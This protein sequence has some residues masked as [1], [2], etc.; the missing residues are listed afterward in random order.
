MITLNLDYL[1][2]ACRI[3]SEGETYNTEFLFPL[4]DWQREHIVTESFSFHNPR[5]SNDYKVIW[6]VR[7]PM[8]G[9]EKIGI[10]LVR[11]TAHNQHQRCKFRFADWMF[12]YKDIDYQQ[13]ADL[14]CE[15][16][17]TFYI[18]NTRIDFAL[19]TD[20]RIFLQ[21]YSYNK[22]RRMVMMGGRDEYDEDTGMDGS[23]FATAINDRCLY[24]SGTFN[25]C[26]EANLSKNRMKFEKDFAEMNQFQA[27]RRRGEVETAYIGGRYSVQ[28]ARL[29][30][31]TREMTCCGEKDFITAAWRQAGYTCERDVW[32]FEIV[33]QKL[34]ALKG[35][36]IYNEDSSVYYDLRNNLMWA[37][38][39]DVLIAIF[40]LLVQRFFAFSADSEKVYTPA[41]LIDSE[42]SDNLTYSKLSDKAAVELPDY[43]A[44]NN[45]TTW[46]C[47]YLRR[48]VYAPIFD[49]HTRDQIHRT[50][51]KLETIHERYRRRQ[52]TDRL[53]L[54]LIGES[55]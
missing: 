28:Y 2:F 30:N 13:I 47:R 31:K 12:Y 6:D 34:T 5:R 17:G 40:N 21:G 16:T 29:Y 19:D 15:E 4:D 52:R 39:R 42:L 14:I 53:S 48:L 32:R 20:E 54:Y 49:Q 55:V 27:I 50:L 38:D 33:L 8:F 45:L 51:L 11:C 24:R 46:M 43:V 1:E 44:N 23:D 37:D 18:G 22:S 36:A 41:Y 7:S 26:K 25:A 3:P 10:F 35:F 9:E